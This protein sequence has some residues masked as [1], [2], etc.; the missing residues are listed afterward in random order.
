MNPIGFEVN[1]QGHNGQMGQFLNLVNTME[2]KWLSLFCYN[3]AH[4]FP[5]LRGWTL[6]NFMRIEVKDMANIWLRGGGGVTEIYV[7][8]SNIKQL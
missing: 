3:L 6:L 2:T 1:V 4:M 8:L 7:A 5:I